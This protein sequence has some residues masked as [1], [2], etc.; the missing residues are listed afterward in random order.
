M[1]LAEVSFIQLLKLFCYSLMFCDQFKMEFSF[2][3]TVNSVYVLMYS[4]FKVS[5]VSV[6]D[7]RCCGR[8][9][10][11]CLVCWG[12]DFYSDYVCTPSNIPEYVVFLL[13]QASTKN[14]SCSFKVT[15]LIKTCLSDASNL[16][17]F[18]SFSHFFKFAF[19]LGFLLDLILVACVNPIH[20]IYFS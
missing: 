5:M 12:Y 4:H 19:W 17:I 14:K 2:L 15:F 18:L 7:Y 3:S 6:I 16:N 10:F 1:L 11:V 13:I 9:C 8:W 20:S